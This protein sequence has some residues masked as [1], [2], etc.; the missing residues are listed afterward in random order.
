M[1]NWVYSK[2]KRRHGSD[3]ALWN[4]Y[5]KKNAFNTKRGRE[6][7]EGLNQVECKLGG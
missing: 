4:V 1:L 5:T 6:K 3:K 2:C 7:H